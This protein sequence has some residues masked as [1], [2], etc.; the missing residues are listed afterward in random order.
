MSVCKSTNRGVSWKRFHLSS[1]EGSVYSLAIDPANSNIIMAGGYYDTG[2]QYLGKIFRSMDGGEHWSDASSGIEKNRNY[3]YALTFHPASSSTIYAGCREGIF[4]STDGGS[5]WNN[6]NA[7]FYNVCA[8][9]FN[10]DSPKT[11]YAATS[12]DGIYTSTDEGLEWSKMNDG[13]TTMEIEC[14]ALDPLNKL[15]YA[16]TNGAGLFRYDISTSVEP[17]ISDQKLPAQFALK[18]NFPNPFNPKTI[19]VYEVPVDNTSPISLK[20]Y[21][22]SGQIVKTLVN[23]NQQAGQFT[24]SWNGC[25][26]LG[27]PVSSGVYLCVLKAGSYSCSRKI[28]VLR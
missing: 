22:V 25:D 13:L 15:L 26:D 12:Y 21:N 27:L 20:I 8:I 14:L 23:G 16:G 2:S 5:N 7:K 17:I 18:P 6:L 1:N 10:M 19:I 3:V 11:I 9:I 24:M 4:R 28:T